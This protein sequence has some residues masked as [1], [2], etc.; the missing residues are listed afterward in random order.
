[1]ENNDVNGITL[2]NY[3]LNVYTH[4]LY[5]TAALAL[6]YTTGKY[7]ALV[8]LPTHIYTAYTYTALVTLP[9]THFNTA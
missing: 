6:N 5:Y 9:R 2:P 1:M 7:T 8:T 4:T 3:A